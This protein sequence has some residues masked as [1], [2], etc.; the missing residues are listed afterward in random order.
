VQ[1]D[2]RNAAA[3][4][5][6]RSPLPATNVAGIDNLFG[7]YAKKFSDEGIEFG[8]T[9]NGSVAYCRPSRRRA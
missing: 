9:V 6:G 5:E 8:L 7:Y 1:N 2:L 3:G 4:L